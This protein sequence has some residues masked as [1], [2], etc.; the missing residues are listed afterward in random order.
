M[1]RMNNKGFTLVEMIGVLAI[2]AVLVGAVAPKIFEAIKN[3]K[4]TTTATLAKTL[5]SATT[6]YYADIGTLLPI[7]MNNNGTIDPNGDIR[8]L[9]TI[10]THTRTTTQDLGKWRKFR[11]P[12]LEKFE[13]T[14]PPIGQTMRLS[15]QNIVAGS[16][17]SATNEA[18]YSLNGGTTNTLSAGNVVS[19]VMTGIS[20]QEWV[21]FE[22]IYEV[23]SPANDTE[24]QR[25]ARGKV[26]YDPN[27]STM[28]VYITNN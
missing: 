18:N 2:I 10:L 4:I 16:A 13:T 5:Q 22:A 15:S 8:S 3:S 12:Y 11:G 28:R 20:A 6:Q 7:Y 17:P 26:K 9:A 25:Q 21:Q 14:N 19:L 27:S 1:K 23:M 24:T